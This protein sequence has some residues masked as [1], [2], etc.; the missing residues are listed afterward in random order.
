MQTAERRGTSMSGSTGQAVDEI[1]A[2]EDS[3]QVKAPKLGRLLGL[4]RPH[5]RSLLLATLL[6][7]LGSAIGVLTPWVAGNVVDAAL[8]ERS[9]SRLNQIV[10]LMI[11]LFAVM[12][13]TTGV[14]VT[15]MQGIGARMLRG[16]RHRLFSHLVTLSPGF[17]ESKRVGELLSRLS[18]DAEVI[19]DA[20]TEQIPDGIQA[21]LRFAGTL[22]ILFVL[23]TRLTIVALIVVPPVAML[24]V[25]FGGRLEKLTTRMHDAMAD[26]SAVSEETFS[27]IRTI[28]AFAREPQA[29][30]RYEAV[31]GRLLGIELKNARLQGGFSGSMLFAAF[32]AFA[33]VLWYGGQLLLENRM[34]PG[35]LTSFLLYTFSIAVSV[36]ELGS[37][38][39]GYREL[40]GA[41]ARFFVLL[42]TRS[43]IEE[44][45]DA[46]ALRRPA[47]RIVFSQVQF[48]YPTAEGRLALDGIDLEIQP[49]EVVGIVGPSGAGKSTLFS[50]LLRLH[51]P[52]A[53]GITIDG[54][55]LRG[56]RLRDL[57]QA[58]GIVPQDIFLFGGTVEENILFGEPAASADEVREAAAAAG[59]D[60]F[61]QRF[62]R[63][64][65]EYVGERGVK[66]SGG[67]RQRIAIARAFLKNPPI[68]LLDEATSHL[69]AESEETVRRA[70]SKL[71]ERRTTLVIAHRLATARQANRIL[72]F[73][74]GRVVGSGNHDSLYESNAVYRRFWELQS[75]KAGEPGDG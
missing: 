62:P 20:L 73:D 45:T 5:W 55:D 60:E 2:L 16:L 59:A 29:I 61:I 44:A 9:L 34:T 56:V 57:R 27:G 74:R 48:S 63:K 47:G 6:M 38:Y 70:L 64:Y 15:L 4:A 53:G 35:D 37:L 54:I 21:A 26:T 23:Q 65:G 51:D 24:A 72:V 46:V 71:L 28:Q 68:L 7:L 49:G 1:L 52:T 11:G 8:L 13:A 43:S 40:K 50:L 3:S 10:L 18:A 41:S 36:G 30:R 25:W 67:E 31:L 32:S 12:G 69:D 75:L 17:Y 66:L 42:D 22:T 14:E 39:A 19:Q 58:I 33:L